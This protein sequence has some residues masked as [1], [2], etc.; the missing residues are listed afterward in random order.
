MQVALGIRSLS[1]SRSLEHLR[2]Q[3]PGLIFGVCSRLACRIA[4]YV[5]LRHKILNLLSL[6]WLATMGAV[7]RWVPMEQDF[8]G[9]FI[10]RLGRGSVSVVWR[11]WR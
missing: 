10:A 1:F 9:G 11:G 8:W 5:A 3:G 2:H 7:L 4:G 6:R